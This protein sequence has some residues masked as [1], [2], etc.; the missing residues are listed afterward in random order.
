MFIITALNNVLVSIE[1]SKG[2]L[3]NFAAK[4]KCDMWI[5]ELL[6]NFE[7]CS[8]RRRITAEYRCE[9]PDWFE[10]LKYSVCENTLFLQMVILVSEF[11]QC[12]SCKSEFQ[13]T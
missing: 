9:D 8:D 4:A 7:Y 12:F 1:K 5:Q 2:L 13:T 6:L 11:C 10:G 3:L